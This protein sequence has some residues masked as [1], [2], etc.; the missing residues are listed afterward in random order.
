MYEAFLDDLLLAIKY[1]NCSLTQILFHFP[2]SS[3]ANI[4]FEY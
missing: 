1:Q 4:I 3:S 2:I